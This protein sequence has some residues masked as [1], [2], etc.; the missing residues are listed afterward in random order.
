MCHG[1]ARGR[2]LERG[3]P[4][5]RP[6]RRFDG[7]PA[8]R[9]RLSDQ[10]AH[11]V[12][13]VE[14]FRREGHRL[15]RADVGI[16]REAFDRR[17][18]LEPGAGPPGDGCRAVLPFGEAAAGGPA[19]PH[20]GFRHADGHRRS[21]MRCRNRRGHH[22]S[23]IVERPV[24]ASGL[25]GLDRHVQGR[26]PLDTLRETGIHRV[27]HA[28]RP[29]AAAAGGQPQAERR[30]TDNRCQTLVSVHCPDASWLS[31]SQYQ[32]GSGTRGADGPP[33]IA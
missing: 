3:R 1:T 26:R 9:Y 8:I 29:R 15:G 30:H 27:P 28:G 16:D 17:A 32:A 12:Q 21:V 7:K 33:I 22:V 6:I 4:H 31:S 10:P 5:E 24:G 11:L 13:P 14:V 19:L 23:R 18:A 20:A 2:R 25:R